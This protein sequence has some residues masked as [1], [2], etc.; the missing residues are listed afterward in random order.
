MKKALIVIVALLVPLLMSPLEPPRLFEI[1]ALKASGQFEARQEFAKKLGNHVMKLR[2]PGVESAG[3]PSTLPSIG[4]PKMF[5]LLIEFADYPHSIEAST[6][7]NMLFG[8]G[9]ENHYPYES[10]KSFY[11]RSSYDK[12]H[13]EGDVYGWYRAAN[14]RS[15]YTD[16][17]EGLIEEAMAYYHSQGARFDKYDNDGNGQVEYFA[18]FWTGPDTGWATFWWG[19]Q[20]YFYDNEFSIDGITLGDF[21][22][23]WEEDNP[24]TIIHETGHALGLPDYYDYDDSTGPRGGTGGLD[25][26]DGVWGD[27]NGYSKWVLGWLTPQVVTDAQEITL[28]PLSTTPSAVVMAR[29]FNGSG[30]DGEF[31][32]IQNREPLGND[33]DLPG[34]GFLIHHVD[35]RRDCDGYTLF[36][37][38]YTEHKLLRL[39]EADGLEE[40]EKNKWGDAGDFYPQGNNGSF[41]PSSFPCSDLY[42][43][44]S[45]L[46]SVSGI[47]AAA[48]SMT[49]R[50]SLTGAADLSAPYITAPAN[51]AVGMGTTPEIR[52]SAVENSAGYELEVHEGVNTIYK[53]GSLAG[54]SLSHTIPQGKLSNDRVYTMWL[55]AKGDGT[56]HGSSEYAKRAVS[57]GCSDRPYWITRT[58]FDPPC[59]SYYAGLAYHPPTGTVV[60]FGG[61]TSDHTFEYDGEKWTEYSTYPAPPDRYYAAMAYDPATQ[62]IL[63]Y[64]GWDEAAQDVFGDTWLY[65]PSNHTWQEMNPAGGPPADWAFKAASDT[66]RNVVVLTAPGQTWEWNGSDWSFVTSSGPGY[67][68]GSMAFDVASSK[69]VYFGGYQY[70]PGVCRN[71]T[72][73]YDGAGWQK[74]SVSG[75]PEKRS[76]SI[77]VYDQRLQKMVLFGGSNEYYDLFN[78]LWSFDGTAW[79]EIDHC[80][81]APEGYYMTLGAYDERRGRLVAA[82]AS[83]ETST[84]ELV[85]LGGSCI[86]VIDPQSRNFGAEGGIGTV[87]LTIT[88]G[89]QWTAKSDSAWI[90]ITSATSG[91]GTAAINYSVAANTGQARSGNINIAGLL[92]AITQDAGQGHENPKISSV[93]KMASP[94]R[95]KVLGS[96]F[97]NGIKVYFGEGSGKIEWTNFSRKNSSTLVLK[98]GASLKALFPK[99]VG[100]RIT[101]E[102]PDGG[103]A[104]TVYTRP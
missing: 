85:G 74:L 66:Q 26:M 80:G 30:W 47:P 28:T 35:A 100:V 68:Y 9:N 101:V 23:Q 62:K 94:F 71:E 89:C 97:Q 56:Q 1:E 18:V 52:W 8:Q 83:G 37:N 54:D 16:D 82:K 92:F 95:L 65:D 15:S 93:S 98:K 19:W 102:N 45:S 43:G 64:G 7:Q 61:N 33:Y 13:I 38:S 84:F 41:T 10:L 60:R 24:G 27:H 55:K 21:S 50:F 75:P 90:T 53:S 11:E 12:L 76:D 88:A 39:M 57:T 70:P 78:D 87:G 91:T 72:W 77:L 2:A 20:G 40:I 42:D 79:E 73:V 48:E 63:L 46:V 5:V 17:A 44:R 104:Y 25:I 29:D 59:D 86:P 103:D 49:A 4:N 58:F 3:G 96:N 34:S 32:L 99:G 36:N 31:F 51:E 6:I 22:W 81:R 67:Y 14:N 69:V